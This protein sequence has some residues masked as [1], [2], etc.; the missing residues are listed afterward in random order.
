[1]DG[2]YAWLAELHNDQSVEVELT[3]KCMG[4]TGLDFWWGGLTGGLVNVT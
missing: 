2:L 1:M 4:S 3:G